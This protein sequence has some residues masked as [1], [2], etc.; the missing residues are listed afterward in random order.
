MR[1]ACGRPHSQTSNNHT[2]VP[3]AS[4]MAI[5]G[6]DRCCD[7]CSACRWIWH[8]AQKST[9]VVKSSSAAILTAI[10]ARPDIRWHGWRSPYYTSRLAGALGS[11]AHRD[12]EAMMIWTLGASRHRRGRTETSESRLVPD[13]AGRLT[14]KSPGPSSPASGL[15]DVPSSREHSA[16]SAPGEATR[17]TQPSE[18]ITRQGRDVPALPV[19]NGGSER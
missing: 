12:I 15:L 18:D 17:K 5:C 4:G 1:V 9:G 2:K 6:P 3:A 8:A 13:T 10:Y 19:T 14:M 11:S 16:N 7:R